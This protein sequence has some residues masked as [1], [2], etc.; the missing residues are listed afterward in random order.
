MKT[1]KVITNEIYLSIIVPVLL[2]HL[3]VKYHKYNCISVFEHL[4]NTIWIQSG[5]KHQILALAT[6]MNLDTF[7]FSSVVPLYSL[8]YIFR[9]TRKLL[10]KQTKNFRNS[11]QAWSVS[12]V[13]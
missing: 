9:Q 3:L 2:L 7:Y 5:S 12:A 10:G 4:M 6:H 1:E 11:N 8:R 13:L